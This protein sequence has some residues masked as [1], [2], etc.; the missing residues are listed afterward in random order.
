MPQI[1]VPEHLFH[2]CNTM[3]D[4][5]EKGVFGVGSNGT[6]PFTLVQ[7]DVGKKAVYEARKDYWGDGPHLERLEFVDLG[8]NAAANISALV[9]GQVDG[10]YMLG[11]DDVKSVEGREELKIYNAK[12]ANTATVSMKCTPR[13]PSCTVGKS[14]SAGSG[15]SPATRAAIVRRALA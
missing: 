12:T 13:A 1:A 11:F 14:R 3:L 8:D 5:A 2:Y 15:D 4:P 6:G 9:S 7:F 10:L